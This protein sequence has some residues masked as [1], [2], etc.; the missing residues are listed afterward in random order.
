MKQ[1]FAVAF[2]PW[3]N[4]LK[5]FNI[6]KYELISYKQLKEQNRIDNSAIITQ[7]DSIFKG[8]IDNLNAFVKKGETIDNPIVIIKDI[9]LSPFSV[10][11]D[12][13]L[14]R[15]RNILAY[16]AICTNDNQKSERN[17]YKHHDPYYNSSIFDLII[18]GFTL[19]SEGLAFSIRRRHGLDT[20]SGLREYN[21]FT[22]PLY[23]SFKSELQYD[24]GLLNAL[25]KTVTNPSENTISRLLSALEL[26]YYAHTDSNIMRDRGDLIMMASAFE[27][28]FDIQS[29]DKRTQLMDK[30]QEAFRGYNE[31]KH[32]FQRKRRTG[33]RTEPNRSWKEHWMCKFY[34]ERNDII[35]NNKTP[36]LRWPYNKFFTHLEIADIVFDLIVRI[37]LDR[38]KFYQ[39]T[40]EDKAGCDTLED[41]LSN[42]RV[43]LQ[44][45][46][47]K[48][49]RIKNMEEF[50]R[51]HEEKE[52]K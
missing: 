35:H 14:L 9:G 18:Q 41:F 37:I 40:E 30:V 48:Q 32:S 11:E 24:E 49:Q 26:F 42:D 44:Q 22:I 50:L 15:L 39:L 23:V 31:S 3:L 38:E 34:E 2:F 7:L 4:T 28:L 29:G 12:N 13:D 36:N 33:T 10:D 6:G 17:T 5:T 46:A 16:S 45:L 21:R 8:Y 52:G 27:I 20:I 51:K 43:S 1:R 19:D 47:Q 25:S